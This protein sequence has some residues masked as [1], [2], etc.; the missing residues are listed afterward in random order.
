MKTQLNAI[1]LMLTFCLFTFI[2][3][4]AG[5]SQNDPSDSANNQ[6]KSQ[7]KNSCSNDLITLSPPLDLDTQGLVWTI[8]NTM[9]HDPLA[10]A[11]KDVLGN[12]QK[13]A[14]TYDQHMGVDFGLANFR[15]MDEGVAIYASADGL[16][17][18]TADGFFDRETKRGK[19][20]SNMIILRHSNGLRTAYAHLRKN[21]LKVKVGDVVSRGQEL[22]FVGSSGDSSGPHLHYEVLNCENEKIDPIKLN[23]FKPQLAINVE[24]KVMDVAVSQTR[25]FGKETP[26]KQIEN[27]KSNSFF[28]KPNQ[29]NYIFMWFSEVSEG[30]IIETTFIDGDNK[31]LNEMKNVIGP[32]SKNHPMIGG[33][34]AEFKFPT[35]GTW[36]V[37]TKL[38]GKKVHQMSFRV[39]NPNRGL[40]TEAAKA[41]PVETP[42]PK[43]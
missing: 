9:D 26:E 24:P 31:K 1:E 28:T 11:I 15:K 36:K 37:I 13:S 41:P 14:R 7:F 29:P 8:T 30:H 10:G 33:T 43:Q 20:E 16:V 40:A 25:N 22:A 18:E 23:L 39:E 2:F 17:E 12:T 34:A 5:R 21:S 32:M 42:Q 27:L 35:E 3:A 38:N 6:I 4:P 19:T